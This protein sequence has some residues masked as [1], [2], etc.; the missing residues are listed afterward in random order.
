MNKSI[1]LFFSY[2]RSFYQYVRSIDDSHCPS[3]TGA[4]V[5]LFIIVQFGQPKIRYFGDKIV[6]KQNIASLHITVY[7][8]E[9]GLF[10]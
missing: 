4:Y 2:K 5:G 3:H 6:V 8:A 10:M 1:S 9:T 7:N